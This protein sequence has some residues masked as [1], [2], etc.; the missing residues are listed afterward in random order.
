M[1]N[2]VL[3]WFSGLDEKSQRNFLAGVGH[4]LTVCARDAN[5]NVRTLEGLNEIHHLLYQAIGRQGETNGSLLWERLKTLSTEYGF[6]AVLHG[7]FTNT[8]NRHSAT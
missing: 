8:M 2:S 3:G 1:T 6:D 7:V 5:G 4:G